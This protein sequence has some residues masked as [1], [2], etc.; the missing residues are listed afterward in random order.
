MLRAGPRRRSVRRVLLALAGA[1]ALVAGAGVASAHELATREFTAPV[2]LW[3]V[4]GGAAATVALT[5]AWVAVGDRV[6]AGDRAETVAAARPVV[7]VPGSVARP[8]ALAVRLGFLALFVAALVHGLVGRQVAAENLATL[9]VWPLLLKGVALVA[10]VAGSPWRVLSPWETLYDGLVALEGRPVAL[11]GAYPERLGAW[12]ALAGFVLL[13]GVVENLTVATRSPGLTVA[14]AAGYAVVMLAGAAAYGREWFARADALAVL[15]DLLGRVAPLSVR[16]DDRGGLAVV[17]RPPWRGATAPLAD[18]S[19]VA[20]AVAAVYTVSFDGFSATRA[21]PALLAGAR[22]A[23]GVAAASIGLYAVGLVGF[24]ATFAAV[25]ALGERLGAGSAEQPHGEPTGWRASARVF[26]ATVL[27]IAAAYEVA[28]NYPYVAANFGQTVAVV[29]DLALG[30]GL[31][32]VSVLSWLPVGAFWASQ[33]GL[34]VAGHVVA[35]VA[36]HRVAVER[37][38]AGARRGH[39]PLAVAMVGYTALSL[40]IVSRPLAG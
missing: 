32:P 21:Y 36:A 39:L 9:V 33:V 29:R 14:V 13:V 5:A 40:W 26:G 18:A 34:V 22:E 31:D 6:S 19:L 24:L 15:F 27:P 37:F 8:L 4:T 28:H 23:V 10:V 16:R 7:T 30:S 20:F 3:L 25:A 38:G 12:P 2:P 1:A 17:A 11:R 35:V